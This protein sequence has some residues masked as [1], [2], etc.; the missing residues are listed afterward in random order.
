MLAPLCF[1]RNVAALG[2]MAVSVLH[3]HNGGIDQHADGQ[4]QAAERHDVRADVQE[5]HGNERGQH[6][7]GQRENGHE[8][9]TEMEQKDDADEAD[10]DGFENAGRASECGSTD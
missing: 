1:A 2:Q 9:G 8:R 10:D 5:V 4:R 3:H 7:D 6:G